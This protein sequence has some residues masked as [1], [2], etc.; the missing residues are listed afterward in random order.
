MDPGMQAAQQASQQH[1][2]AHRRFADGMADDQIR[3]SRERQGRR[4]TPSPLRAIGL[5]IELAV[6]AVIV[7]VAIALFTQGDAHDDPSP[8]SGVDVQ[9]PAPEMP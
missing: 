8:G 9:L 7:M 1:A 3:R 6:L 4:R 2:A 5:L